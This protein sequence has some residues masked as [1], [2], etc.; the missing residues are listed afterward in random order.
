[1]AIA[2]TQ[3][4][5]SAAAPEVNPVRAALRTLDIESS[6]IDAL[7][8]AI[9]GPLCEIFSGA[10]GLLKQTTEMNGRVIVTGMGKSGHI[11]RKIAATFASTGTPSHFV[12][13]GEASHGDLGMIVKGDCVIAISNSG[14]TAELSPTL[15]HCKRFAIPI[16]GIT[17]KPQ[18][19]LASNSDYLLA[20]PPSPEACPLGLAP[21]TSTTLTLAL[22]D[23]I[24]VALLEMRGFTAQHFRVFHPGG[25][26]GSSL[27]MI[28]D[29]MLAGDALPLAPMGMKLGEAVHIITAKKKGCVGIVDANG[30][31]VGMVTD[32]D[33]RRAMEKYDHP[34]QEP[35]DKVMSTSPKVM[36]ADKLASE[37]VNFMNSKQITQIFIVDGDKPVGL[38]HAHDC[39]RAGVA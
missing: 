2:A 7:S 3:S 6:A 18:S 17:S 38:L 35:V 26:L 5:E 21:T 39:L 9:E 1:M 23:A 4:V 30:T 32:G 12:H 19:T 8:S 15:T 36:A 24:A 11:A 20:L 33:V 13:P 34:A 22:G 28:R 25:K 16:I 37:A 14:E 31:L 10:V 29:L 27:V